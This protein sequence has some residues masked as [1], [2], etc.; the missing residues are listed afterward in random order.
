MGFWQKFSG[1]DKL[2]GTDGTIFHSFLTKET[3]LNA[4]SNDICRSIFLRY[5]E[6]VEHL[7][8][9]GYRFTAP[10]DNF[11]DPRISEATRCYCLEDELE[12]CHYAGV[13]PL[14][15]C[16]QGKYNKKAAF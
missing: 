11:E 16:T 15:S 1:C 7:G 8:I 12:K 10:R 9:P 5:S 14:E 13:L 3:I 6:D 4:F 2:S